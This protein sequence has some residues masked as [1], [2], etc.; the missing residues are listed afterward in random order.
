MTAHPAQAV[1]TAEHSPADKRRRTLLT[2]G[3]IGALIAGG[4]YA[5]YW[6]N[7]MLQVE[8]TEDAYV[9]GNIVQV[10]SQVGGT[11]VAIGADNTD[12]VVAG[13]SLI[14]LNPIDAQLALERSEA[15]L[16]KTV[17]QV[18]SQFAVAS[19]MRANV[20][21]R[22]AELRRVQAD[23]NRRSELVHSGAVSG[24][25][26]EHASESVRTASAA[27]KSAEEQYAASHAYVDGT[28]VAT[29]PDVL[30]AAAQVKDAY[31]AAARA[32][33]PAPVA[34]IVARRNVQVGQRVTAG[35]SMMSIIPLESLWVTANFKESQLRHIHAGQAVLLTA[36]V[37]GR[38]VK[39]QGI[40]VGQEAGTGSA[41]S[42]MPAQN[43]TGNW[44]KVVQ[45]LPV[46]IALDPIQVRTNPLQLGLSMRVSVDTSKRDGVHFAAGGNA[47]HAYDTDVF[48]HEG[49]DA[50]ALVTRIITTNMAAGAPAIAAN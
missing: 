27:L 45:R 49:K 43:A 39:Y 8:T 46:R 14:K 41:F 4:G 48:A 21:L 22:R 15:A 2:A 1:A 17:R 7:V 13:Q 34:G 38:E 36:D 28:T 32:V 3:L 23:M 33:V 26:L 6:S 30:S 9:E 24:E 12:R 20:E 42:L 18:R 50:A 31:I 16:G 19:Q 10:T 44:I 35:S 11:V 47:A 37:Y 40:V 29:H 25:D 5:F